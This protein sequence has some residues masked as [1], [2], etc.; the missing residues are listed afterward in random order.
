MNRYRDW[1]N[2]ADKDLDAAVDS[3]KDE[4]FE[5]ACFQAQQ[6][7]GKALK[8]LL[9]C[10]NFDVRGH[11]LL[12]LLK[13]WK[14][15]VE[16]GSGA[17]IK[18]VEFEA[19]KEKCQELDRHYI[20]PRYPNGFA[21]GYPAEYYNWKIA[22]TCIEN[23]RVIIGFVKKRLKRYPHLDELEAFLKRI[24]KDRVIFILLYGSLAKSRF[25]QY[26]DID[27]LCVHDREFS[28]LRERFLASYKYSD[29]LVQTKTLTFDEFKNGLLTG[30]SFLHG[31]IR[32]G[33]ILFSKIPIK[34]L[35]G[36]V[37]QGAKKL[38][39]KSLGPY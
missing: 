34:D 12:Y 37:R 19:L 32:D 20:Q 11:G 18:E 10:L 3:E 6:A 17:G 38:T 31:I 25:T 7:A 1:L 24:K 2:Q 35:E 28:D 8:A 26:S 5:W 36:W 15:I 22:N 39:V 14:R 16:S 13:E 27:V 9:L 21:N 33:I 29:G 4:H 30:N 23:A